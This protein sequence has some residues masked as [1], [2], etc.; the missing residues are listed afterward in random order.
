MSFS[1]WNPFS[2]GDLVGDLGSSILTGDGGS[3]EVLLLGF[4][5]CGER[6]VASGLRLDLVGSRGDGLSGSGGISFSGGSPLRTLGG[7]DGE[8]SSVLGS[9]PGAVELEP[10]ELG[11]TI[12]VWSPRPSLT[13][14][15][16]DIAAMPWG[17]NHSSILNATVPKRFAAKERWSLFTSPTR[18]LC[19]QS[20]AVAF[21]ESA[22]CSGLPLLVLLRGPL[23][24]DFS[25][26]SSVR[27]DT[28]DCDRPGLGYGLGF[29]LLDTA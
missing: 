29:G 19:V 15:L 16:F 11:S 28:G 4:E 18:I 2:R 14:S 5:D 6:N 9:V 24:I 23:L 3:K 7:F 8:L 20:D 10:E 22:V 13:S 26:D 12:C 25:E 1:G 27:R 21:R 17:V